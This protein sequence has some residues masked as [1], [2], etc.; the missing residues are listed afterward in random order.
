MV[1]KTILE[2]ELIEDKVLVSNSTLKGTLVGKGFGESKGRE[3]V[4]D[5]YE[6]LFLVANKK[7]VVK[8]TNKKIKGKELLTL[9][10]TQDKKF[11]SKSLVFS[12]I[13]ERGQVVKTGLKF[14]FDFRVYPKGKKMGKAHSA[15]GIN[16]TSENEKLSMTQVSR[17]TRLAGNIHI[18][19]VLA[20]VDRENSINYYLLDRKLF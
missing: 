15:F 3:L 2:G 8:R 18:K 7:I 11:Y 19:A 10:L 9:G 14:G 6:A 16:V 13:R 4:L 12:D 5:L 17:I 1:K 20:V